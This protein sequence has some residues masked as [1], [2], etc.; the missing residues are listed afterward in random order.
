MLTVTCLHNVLM[1]E[2][3]LQ[4]TFGVLHGCSL[5]LQFQFLAVV[6]DSFQNLEK[7]KLR[8]LLLHKREA[9][10]KAFKLLISKQVRVEIVICYFVP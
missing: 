3:V 8:N 9:C 5:P 7:T 10:E 2:I 6:Y 4:I 1:L